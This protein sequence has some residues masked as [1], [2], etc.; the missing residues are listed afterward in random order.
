MGLS[1]SMVLSLAMAPR[2]SSA[3]GGAEGPYGSSVTGM[4]SAC[5]CLPA[6]PEIEGTIAGVR[7]AEDVEARL[8]ARG[9]LRR[10]GGAS[11][12]CAILWACTREVQEVWVTRG[13]AGG[14]RAHA[15]ELLVGQLGLA[16][17]SEEMC[18]WLRE[19][20]RTSSGRRYRVR[21]HGLDLRR[22]RYGRCLQ[23]RRLP[24]AMYTPS[25]Y[26]FKPP[27]TSSHRR[28]LSTVSHRR[29]G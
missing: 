27:T 9:G 8:V 22:G 23:P 29:L 1:T 7:H 25:R 17:G 18:R 12:A 14:E 21:C 26:S 11:A 4:V 20:R 15:A 3:R 19:A 10:P 5:P 13:G 24:R 28:V 2:P 6:L 16:L